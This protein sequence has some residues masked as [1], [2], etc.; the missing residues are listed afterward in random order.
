MLTTSVAIPPAATWHWTRALLRRSS[1]RIGTS[2]DLPAAVLVDRDG[3]IVKDVPYNG[4]PERV[5]PMPGAAAALQRLRRAGIPI[6]VITNQ[7]G[8]GRG[9]IDRRAVDAVNARI[10]ALLGPFDA[11]VVCPHTDADGCDCRKPKPGLVHQAARR[12]GVSPT[13]CVVIG[14][15]GA[16]MGSA[17]AQRVLAP[18]SCRPRQ[19][20][21]EEVRAAPQCARTLT[22]A[23][24]VV[25]AGRY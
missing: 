9:L 3:T 15:I 13:G 10:D 16:D 2:D 19:T 6:A 23:V 21:P 14:D 17:H 20:R 8:I 24:D 1:R 7:S 18:F 25:L 11:W 22:E 12:L 5:E 4:D